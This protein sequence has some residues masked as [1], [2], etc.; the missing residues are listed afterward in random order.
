MSSDCVFCK[1]VADEIPSSRVYEDDTKIAFMDIQ[2]ARP[3]HVLL[4]PRKHYD[5]LTDMPGEETGE[6]LTALPRLAAAVVK[7]VEADG[8]N[9]FQSNGACAGQVVPH[10][11]FHII[12]R[13]DDDGLRFHLKSGSAEKGD[14]EEIRKRIAEAMGIKDSK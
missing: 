3:G 5:R 7:A 10:V 9:V 13:H 2:P 6:L 1:I 4:V 8:F 14:I 11:H 12:P